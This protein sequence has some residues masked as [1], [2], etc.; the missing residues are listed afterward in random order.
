MKKIL[1][2]LLF[3]VLTTVF[4]GC[5]FVQTMSLAV[6]GN[7]KPLI[8][9]WPNVVQQ[10]NIPAMDQG[11]ILTAPKEVWIDI[12]KTS[13]RGTTAFIYGMP[14]GQSFFLPADANLK[15]SSTVVITVR[16]RDS[17]GN[18]IGVTSRSYTFSNSGYISYNQY[19]NVRRGELQ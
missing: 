9:E 12:I 1:Y 13:G 15:Y 17:R 18:L 19:W 11:V 14:P 4:Y 7:Y 8:I 10:T 3:F 6:T 2:I 16:G 5:G